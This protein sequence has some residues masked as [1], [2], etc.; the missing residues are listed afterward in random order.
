MREV[1]RSVIATGLVISAFSAGMSSQQ[2]GPIEKVAAA[3]KSIALHVHGNHHNYDFDDREMVMHGIDEVKLLFQSRVKGSLYVLLDA[4]GSSTGGGMGQCGAGQEEY[5]I[6][7]NLDAKWELDDKK[8][9]LIASCF[10]TIESTEEEPY[11]IDHGKLTADYINY[12]DKVQE[13]L[14]YDSFKP[15]KGWAVR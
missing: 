3:D 14:T 10:A 9:E 12:T 4:K 7:L 15:E 11:E 6:W 1:C 8:L 13:Q 2:R 5:L